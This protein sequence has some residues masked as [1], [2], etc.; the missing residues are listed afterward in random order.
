[1]LPP[2]RIM[3]DSVRVR[4]TLWYTAV[5]ALV[6]VALSLITYFI[7]WRSTVQRTDANLVE[8]S[9]A[10]LTTLNAEVND[11]TGPDALKMAAQV[12][13]TEHRFRDHV[14]AIFDDSGKLV[15]SSQDVPSANSA[16]D[17]SPAGLLSSVTFRRFLDAAS[18]ADRLFGEVKGNKAGYRGFAR[19]FS[20]GGK[21]Y[22]LVILQ[23]LHPQQEMLEEVTST[24]AWIIPIAILLASGG[25]YFLARKS[26]APVVAMSSQAGR[27]GAANLHERLAVQNEKDELGHLARSFNSLLDRLSRSFERQQRFMAD[28]SH[29][30]RTPVAI[31]RGE[32]EVALSQQARSAEEYRE[33]LG[34]LH[35]EAARLTH[36]VE[37]LFTLTRADTGQYPLQPR[38][39][40][41]DE[42]AAECVHSARTLALAKRITLNLEAAPES[43]ILADESLLRR[44]I[45]NLLDN[46]I[47]Y[48]PESG[49]VTVSCRRTG[50]EYAL[51]ITDTGGGIPADLQPRIFERFFR[52]DKAR[53]RAENDGGGAGLGLSISRW[54]AEAHHGRLEVTHSDSTGSTFTAYLPA[55]PSP[56][57]TSS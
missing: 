36:I 45:L 24:F 6:L 50:T 29:E 21:A 7:F 27:I 10:F 4:L 22:N 54:I 31:L 26:L 19:R 32:S 48:T 18:R 41:L 35:Q 51:S 56:A 12:A 44:M 16:M 8:L 15:V 23:S 13:I 33:S 25:G 11:Q 42:L 47:K 55:A 9:N 38:D 46:A 52:A 20:S 39:F 53:S 34:V 30:L 43:P 5:L 1:M 3:L 37:D 28:A 17:S 2:G 14:F 40:Y 57:A 49:C